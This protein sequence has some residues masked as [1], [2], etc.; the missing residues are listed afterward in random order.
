MTSKSQTQIELKDILDTEA[1]QGLMDDFYTITNFGVRII[2]LKGEV[3]VGTGWQDICSKF[4]RVNPATLSNCI[5]SDTHLTRHVK[6]GD[7]QEY[8]CQNSL[9]DIVTPIFVNDQHVGNLF[10]GQFMYEDEIPEYEV[11]LHQAEK[12]GFDQQ[13]YLSA[14]SHVPRWSRAKVKNVMSFYSR[15]ADTISNLLTSNLLLKEALEEKDKLIE[16]LQNSNNKTE[17]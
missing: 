11:F 3:L 13:E 1:I 10:V 6:K 2:N 5:E 7:I 14:L 12:Y 9:R 17:Q 4:H 16:D 15:F 8:K